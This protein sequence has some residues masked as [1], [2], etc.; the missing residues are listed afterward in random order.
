LFYLLPPH[1]YA[2]KELLLSLPNS[3]EVEN[4]FEAM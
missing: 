3:M 1:E 2:Y 4:A